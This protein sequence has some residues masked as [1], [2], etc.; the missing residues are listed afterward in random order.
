MKPENILMEIEG[1]VKITDFGLSKEGIGS[2]LLF[3][4]YY[5]SYYY[6]LFYFIYFFFFL[7]KDEK[8]TYTLCGTPEYLAPEILLG[9]GHDKAVD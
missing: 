6:Y 5:Y 1:H 7:L 4:L 8:K 9:D 2:Y 3:K